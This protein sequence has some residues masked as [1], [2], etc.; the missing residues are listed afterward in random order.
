[1]RPCFFVEETGL[2][3]G[4]KCPH[5]ARFAKAKQAT[6]SPFGGEGNRVCISI[7]VLVP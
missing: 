6:L 4:R 5:P 2:I 3:A 7:F 1:M